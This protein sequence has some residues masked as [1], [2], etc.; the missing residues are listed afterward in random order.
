MSGRNRALDNRKNSLPRDDKRRLLLGSEVAFAG[1]DLQVFLECGNFDRAVAA[2]GIEVGGLV[3][4]DVLAAEFVFD[5]GEGMGNVLH[6]ERKESASAGG[7][8]ELFENFIAA[9]DETAI[10]G[11]DGVDD[12]LCALRHF[13][14]LCSRIFALII[15]SITHDDDGL[16]RGMI[17]AVFQKLFFAGAIDGIVERGA[18]AILQAMNSIGEQLHVVGEILS[19]LTLFVETDDEGFVEAGANRVLEEIGGRILLKSE[20]AV[21]GPADIDEQP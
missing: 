13:D 20:A 2:I 8:G 9:Q 10:V 6:L 14:G 21:D 15:F 16:A 17:G 7:F 12:D 11:G 4:D 3:G 1:A 19:E 18:S 5:G